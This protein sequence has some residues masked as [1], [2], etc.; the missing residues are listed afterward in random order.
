MNYMH[1]LCRASSR[2]HCSK[3]DTNRQDYDVL[4]VVLYNCKQGLEC[5]ICYRA[6]VQT[7]GGKK[8]SSPWNQ[9][10][11]ENIPLPPPKKNKIHS[12]NHQNNPLDPMGEGFT[13]LWHLQHGWI[14]S[15]SLPPKTQIEICTPSPLLT[16]TVLRR[17]MAVSAYIP[18]H[19]EYCY[20][21]WHQ[22]GGKGAC[23]KGYIIPDFDLLQRGFI[24]WFCSPRTFFTNITPN[25]FLTIHYSNL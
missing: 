16:C 4:Y 17:P 10:G 9:K 2:S 25:L 20:H 21:G 18:L 7:A 23:L 3:L 6:K 1:E 13:L 11:A 12:A 19:H 15:T 5:P 14:F 22:V 24:S 8:A